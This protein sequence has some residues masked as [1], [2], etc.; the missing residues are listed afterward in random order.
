MAEWV[1]IFIDLTIAVGTTLRIPT[2]LYE[3]LHLL[4]SGTGKM[5]QEVK[6][7]SPFAGS[8][9]VTIMSARVFSKKA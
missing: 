1:T 5:N 3:K 9:H 6:S 7:S 4:L 2:Q 8:C